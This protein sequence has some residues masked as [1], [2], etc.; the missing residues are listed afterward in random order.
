ML[1]LLVFTNKD[2]L[3]V[4][5]FCSRK[6]LQEVYTW[7]AFKHVMPAEACLPRLQL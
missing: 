5:L 2:I 6:H 7:C 4:L 1:E 3:A